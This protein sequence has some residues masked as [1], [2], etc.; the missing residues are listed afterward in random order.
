MKKFLILCALSGFALAANMHFEKNQKCSECHP[1]IY[2]EYQKSQHA[3]AT[4]FKDKIHG[5]VYDPH[6][7]NWKL[8]KY[9][10]GACHVPTA[11]NL[12]ELLAA[13]N[14]VTPDA[15]N[16]T[17]NEAIACAYCHRIEDTMPG[18]AFSKNVVSKEGKV[19]FS[20]KSNPAQSPFHAV[21]T[22][23]NVFK[24]GKMCL[25]C[26]ARKSN[27]KGFDVC[28][29]DINQKAPKKNCIEC[30]MHKVDGAPSVMSKA[31]KHTF[32]GFPGLHGDL[33]NLSQYIGMEITSKDD[34]KMFTV[35]IDHDVPHASLLH[36]LRMGKLEVTVKSGSDVTKMQTRK[37][38]KVIGNHEGP[39][40]SPTPPWLATMI[41]KDTRIPANSTKA[42]PYAWD[43]KSGDVITAKFGYL[44]VKPKALKKFN[45]K[46]NKEAT[47]FR[48]ISEK[49]FTVK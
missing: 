37:L 30:H 31:T 32:H 7:Q 47:K 45:L 39:S 18:K 34:N 26:H 36:P 43:L 33:T 2:S 40:P 24:D 42:Y 46:N 35:T 29:T 23:K 41:I 3:N 10:C 15:D 38:V 21:K 14:G 48:I 5:A 9:R 8:E 44:L 22:N 28:E 27:K 12:S 1:S 20:N 4:I 6:P 25:G 13:N 17:Q 19:Y 11:D 49:S 16:E